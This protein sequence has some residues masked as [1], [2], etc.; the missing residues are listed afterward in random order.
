MN[1]G[2]GKRTGL[3]QFYYESRPETGLLKIELI[4]MK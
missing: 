4:Q 1:T 2:V 3:V